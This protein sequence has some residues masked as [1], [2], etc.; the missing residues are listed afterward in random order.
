MWKPN[1]LLSDRVVEDLRHAGF[2]ESKI[3]FLGWLSYTSRALNHSYNCV[4]AAHTLL[5]KPKIGKM[6]AVFVTKKKES[7]FPKAAAD[8]EV[9]DMEFG[10][11]DKWA[12]RREQ[13]A[14][15]QRPNQNR[16]NE[17]DAE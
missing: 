8:H 3:E 14:D 10:D 13:D 7:V 12:E 6:V 1:Q 16:N 4:K 5:S 17:D 9:V 15:A 2:S 11:L